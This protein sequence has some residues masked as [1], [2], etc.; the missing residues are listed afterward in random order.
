MLPIEILP[1]A[2]A[3]N[4]EGYELLDSGD[5]WKLERF[6]KHV[7]IRPEPRAMWSARL[8]RS[9]W[10]QA[11]ACFGE[12]PQGVQFPET[13]GGGASAAA[14]GRRA[15]AAAS[16]PKM[17]TGASRRVSGPGPRPQDSVAPA[18]PWR[19]KA[20]LSLDSTWFVP[21]E[22][23]TLVARLAPSGHVGIFP[24]YG[25]QWDWVTSRCA[26]S[27][28]PQ[29]RVL[30]LF[31]H[32]GAAALTT[33]AAQARATHVDSSK[34]AMRWARENQTHSRLEQ[35]PVRWLLDDVQE[36]VS[37][38]IRRESRYEGIILDPPAFGRGTNRERWTFFDTLPTLLG[39]CRKLLAEKPEFLLITCYSVVLSPRG[40]AQ[41]L[42]AALEGLGG[43]I[44]AGELELR[45]SN[46]DPRTLGVAIFARW[47]A[48]RK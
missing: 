20:P 13:S 4:D 6:G 30:S 8:P 15:I 18:S 37:R 3:T 34:P 24:E 5:G 38:D 16:A 27:A 40:L 26:G 23:L 22:R 29:P 41:A 42:A 19:V 7:L 44:E 45:E 11:V 43:S 39:D 31:G 33:A 9:R 47:S 28:T 25:P 2:P 35:A 21:R 36:F 32:T 10:S 1:T 12:G 46:R 48:R 17:K 14:A